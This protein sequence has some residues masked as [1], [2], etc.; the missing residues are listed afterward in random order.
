MEGG[1]PSQ[2][3][4]VSIRKHF[5]QQ[6]RKV[7]KMRP[8]LE[9]YDLSVDQVG[10]GMRTYEWLLLQLQKLMDRE[11][12]G[13]NLNV[14]VTNLVSRRDRVLCTTSA[15]GFTCDISYCFQITARDKQG[16]EEARQQGSKHATKQR[17]KETDA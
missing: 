14:K 4:A 12:L 3:M 9:W 13:W 2:E 15:S 6:M 17:H 7:P 1:V 16:S 5:Y 10:E 8:I 11:R